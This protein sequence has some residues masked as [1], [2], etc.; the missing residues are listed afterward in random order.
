MKL[1]FGYGHAL[2]FLRTVL[3]GR[4]AKARQL[5]DDGERGASAV[6]WVVITAIVVIIIVAVGGVLY[7]VLKA[8][9]TQACNAINTAGGAN[10]NAN[11]AGA[12]CN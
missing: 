4:Y 3:V 1:G 12:T 7:N 11:P 6:E 9:T 8:K 10:G 5:A 2:D